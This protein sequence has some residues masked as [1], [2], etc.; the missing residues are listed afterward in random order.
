MGS[1][2]APILANIFMGHYEKQWINNYLG[3]KP[4]IYKRYVDDIFCPFHNEQDA[5][6]FFDYLN[7]PNIKFTLE[8]EID[9]KLCFP[10]VL[11]KRVSTKNFETSIF[12][13]STFTGLYT[14]FLSFVPKMYKIALIKT[15]LD[16]LY[17]ICNNWQVFHKD[18]K[19]L[20]IILSKNMFPPRLIEEHLKKY[21]NNKQ[22]NTTEEIEEDN[23]APNY[24]K[25]PYTGE[26]SDYISKQIKNICQKYC[27]NTKIKIS[28][29]M[30]K[31]GDMFPI[32]SP[33]PRNLES[34]VVYHFVCAACNGSYVGETTRYFEIR[35]HEHLYKKTQPTAIYQHL[36]KNPDCKEKC[37]ESCFKILDRARTKFTLEVKEAIHTQWLKPTITK[38]QNLSLTVSI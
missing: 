15:L 9:S 12:R 10:D 14:N 21:L 28:F 4:K 23:S 29:N 6:S 8:K 35:V 17:C 37:D 5:L 31:V 36:M 13:K 26:F 20:K 38:Q 16:R 19:E 25:L 32:K 2:L 11:I 7:H 22:Q 18:L 3:N 27:K 33:L 30:F 34:G 24:F 1:P